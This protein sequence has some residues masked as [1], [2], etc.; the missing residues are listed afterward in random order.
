MTRIILLRL[1]EEKCVGING[2]K[3]IYPIKIGDKLQRK[4]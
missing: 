1:Q 4:S 3:Q 2:W